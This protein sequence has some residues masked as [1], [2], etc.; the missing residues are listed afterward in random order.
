MQ[1]VKAWR[2]Y[3]PVV[4]PSGMATRIGFASLF[5][6]ILGFASALYVTLVFSRY[7]LSGL[8]ATL[9]TLTMG[10]LLAMAIEAYLRKARRRMVEAFVAR[11]ERERIEGLVERLLGARYPELSELPA[12][13]RTEAIRAIDQLQAVIT[14]ANLLS[15]IDAPF[16]LIFL[17]VILLIA[18]PL[19]LLAAFLVMLAWGLTLL[20][21]VTLHSATTRLQKSQAELQSIVASADRAETVRIANAAGLL[22]SK[23]LGA[24]GKVRFERFSANYQQEAVQSVSQLFSSLISVMTI[25]IGAKLATEGLLDF[26]LLFGV[27]IL[28]G[29]MLAIAMRPAQLLMQIMQAKQS[30]ASIAKMQELPLEPTR[31]TELPDY[32]GAW[33]FR[34]VSAAY[35]PS[36]PAIFESLTL[37]VRPGD[38]IVISGANGTGKTTIARLLMGMLDPTRGDIR[39]DGVN[40]RQCTPA[41][42]RRQVVYVPQEPEFFD[43]TLLENMT[44]L[45]PAAS[46]ERVREVLR[47]VGLAQLVDHH[48]E[49]LAMAVTMGGRHFSLGIRRRLAL[50]RALLTAGR[51]VLIDEPTEGLDAAGSQMI[52]EIMTR[53][54]LEGRT[55]VVC[56]PQ[57]SPELARMATLVDLNEKPV[58][59]VVAPIQNGLGVK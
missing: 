56:L 14:P 39:V 1:L 58:P 35:T 21:A 10:A 4:M 46:E 28:S 2:E 45:A 8:D 22:Q 44:S 32:A 38:V 40:I 19:G 31:G 27:S 34:N 33:E 17:L 23:W 15:F 25:G 9:L 29:R 51:L 52:N 42:W 13:Q 12:G 59:R 49:G 5:I 50:A 3:F 53:L 57:P 6:H 41:W 48:P 43:G 37:V 36:G 47:E 18:W 30:L 55:L 11:V 20:R 16:A 54:K 26:S 24:A 7:S